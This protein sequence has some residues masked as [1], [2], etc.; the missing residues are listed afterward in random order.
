MVHISEVQVKAPAPV[1]GHLSVQV[2]RI[3]RVLAELL[4]LS[5]ADSHVSSSV[6]FNTNTTLFKQ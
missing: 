1:V 5:A 6:L 4:R 3:S 2:R